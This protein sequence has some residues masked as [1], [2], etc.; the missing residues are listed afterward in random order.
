MPAI[1]QADGAQFVRSYEF[2][3][4]QDTRLQEKCWYAIKR[5]RACLVLSK[6]QLDPTMLHRDGAEHIELRSDYLLRAANLRAASGHTVLFAGNDA[7]EE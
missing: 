1:N 3:T 2:R 4:E 7:T 5:I 6:F